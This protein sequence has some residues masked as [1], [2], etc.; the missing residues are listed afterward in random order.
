MTTPLHK[1]VSRLSAGNG[2]NRRRYVVTLAP[3]DVIGFRDARTRTTYWT[4][5][6]S[7]YAATVRA[8][9][10][11]KREDQRKARKEGKR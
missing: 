1:P 5:L 11:R 4:T 9:V 3:G 10:A 6:A 7:C 8:E 2:V